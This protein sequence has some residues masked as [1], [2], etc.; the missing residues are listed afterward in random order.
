MLSSTRLKLQTN[1]QT[2]G[3][4]HSQKSLLMALVFKADSRRAVPSTGM[5]FHVGLCQDKQMTT[6][7][8]IH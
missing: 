8:E 1:Q 5:D 4:V 6:T 2:A 3:K 7:C